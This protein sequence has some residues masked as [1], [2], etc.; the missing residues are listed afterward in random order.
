MHLRFFDMISFWSPSRRDILA[1]FLWNLAPTRLLDTT[2][3]HRHARSFVIEPQ[4]ISSLINNAQTTEFTVWHENG[5][6]TSDAPQ[7]LLSTQDWS[8]FLA[9]FSR[10]RFF[11]AEKNQNWRCITSTTMCV[12]S[13]LHNSSIQWTVDGAGKYCCK[14]C[15]N[16]Q[17]ECLKYDGNNERLEA[18]PLPEEVRPEGVSFGIKWFVAEKPNTSNNVGFKGMWRATWLPSFAR[19]MESLAKRSVEELTNLDCQFS[20]GEEI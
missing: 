2:T 4:S 10:N 19:I 12:R 1:T 8:D 7:H 18:L 11:F 9:T 6:L 16:T 14:G 17:R 15:F 20:E 3:N 13:V 5:T